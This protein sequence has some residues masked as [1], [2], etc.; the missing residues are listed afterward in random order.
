MILKSR[1]QSFLLGEGAAL[2][3]VLTDGVTGLPRVRGGDASPVRALPPL[4][5]F[6]TLQPSPGRAAHPYTSFR[7]MTH[8]TEVTSQSWGNRGALLI[9]SFYRG[10]VR[11][12]V[13]YPCSS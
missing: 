10:E 1:L 2:G 7:E 12:A 13:I 3:T 6:S 8:R 9:S 11:S 4:K 5:Q